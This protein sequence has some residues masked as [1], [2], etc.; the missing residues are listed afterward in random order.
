MSGGWYCKC[1]ALPLSRM[2]Q[3]RSYIIVRQ[4]RGIG[5][6]LG[7]GQAYLAPAAGRCLPPQ[8]AGPG[9]HYGCHARTCCERL[10]ASSG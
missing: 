1:P 8:A 2:G 10:S 6:N 3:A 7:Y 4:L 9:Y 5:Q